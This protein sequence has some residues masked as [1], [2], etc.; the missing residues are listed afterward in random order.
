M[1]LKYANILQN[2]PNFFWYAN[3]P[4]GNPATGCTKQR[5]ELFLFAAKSFYV[6]FLTATKFEQKSSLFMKDWQERNGQHRLV[7]MFKMHSEWQPEV[8]V[9]SG[10]N[11][12][13]RCLR[14]SKNIAS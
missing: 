12:G 13:T 4:S 7:L 6:D 1:A 5:H 14:V 11:K 2:V 10:A 3:V 9:G 8:V